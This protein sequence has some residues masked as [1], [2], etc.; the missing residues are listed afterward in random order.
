VPH[1]PPSNAPTHFWHTRYEEWEYKTGVVKQCDSTGEDPKC[2][3]SVNPLF[4]NVDD[5]LVYLGLCM[6]S[7][8]GTCPSKSIEISDADAFLY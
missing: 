4:L 8:C 5:H 7:G 2:S 6:G 1:N 3:D